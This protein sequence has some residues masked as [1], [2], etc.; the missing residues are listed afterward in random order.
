MCFTIKARKK[1]ESPNE[2]SKAHA[3]RN[4]KKFGKALIA[5]SL[6]SL[7]VFKETRSYLFQ[8]GD[9]IGFAV[10]THDSIT[11]KNPNLF[12]KLNLKIVLLAKMIKLFGILEGFGIVFFLWFPILQ[13]IFKAFEKESES[14]KVLGRKFAGRLA[15]EIRL[16]KRFFWDPVSFCKINDLLSQSFKVCAVFFGQR[17]TGA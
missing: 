13:Q 7:A 17:I 8:G 5:F 2:I 9:G 14:L 10:Y 4:K 11:F 16:A 15:K 1:T 3:K 12:Q 6:K